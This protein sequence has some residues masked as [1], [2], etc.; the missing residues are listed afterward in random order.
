MEQAEKQTL[1]AVAGL[2][3]LY[4]ISV[5]LFASFTS[6]SFNFY[7]QFIASILIIGILAW[8]QRR[9]VKGNADLHMGRLSGAL[10]SPIMFFGL[11]AV[12]FAARGASV[13][14]P[15]IKAVITALGL[16]MMGVGSIVGPEIRKFQDLDAYYYEH[17][18]SE[19]RKALE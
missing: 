6:I 1:G 15:G 8:T 13:I 4:I 12:V 3:V 10:I 18:V 11:A 2:Q 19:K 17:F 14:D 7:S 16:G 9:L 5:Y